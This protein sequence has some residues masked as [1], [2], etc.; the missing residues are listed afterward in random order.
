M[1]AA[2]LSRIARTPAAAVR[3]PAREIGRQRRRAGRVVRGVEQHLA[4]VR[5][6]SAF[7]P[8]RPRDV[9]RAD[10]TVGAGGHGDAACVEHLEHSHR[11]D[12]VVD[13]MAPRS[14][15][16]GRR[17][18]REGCSHETIGAVAPRRL[19]RATSHAVARP[20]SARRRARRR[21]A[22][23]PPTPQRRH[24]PTTTGTPGL[25]MPAFLGGDL[26]Q[27]RP[28]VLLMIERDRR[29]RGRPPAE[30]R[31]SHRAGRPARPRAPRSRR[32]RGG[33][34]R[35]PTAVVTSK[36]VGVRLQDAPPRSKRST[37]SRTSATA[38]RSARSRRPAGRR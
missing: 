19:R 36:N 29:D 38:L 8:P 13:L 22:R 24:R 4:A 5:Q 12:R 2:S 11:D 28:E 17:R 18:N 33:T 30:R 1:P 25:M 32:R 3:P 9:A 31:W 20:G 15:E 37:A 10:S 21:R 35:T 34:A 27:R 16:R 7:E 23:W 6:A 26:A 14:A